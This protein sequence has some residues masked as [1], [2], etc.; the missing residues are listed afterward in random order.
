MA[1][2]LGISELLSL[3][4]LVPF[5]KQNVKIK[6]KIFSYDIYCDATL[7][8]Q[9][10]TST[11]SPKTRLFIILQAIDFHQNHVYKSFV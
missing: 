10:N 7:S 8:D 6:P 4:V 3:G 11:H 1:E 9:D 2:K 5:L